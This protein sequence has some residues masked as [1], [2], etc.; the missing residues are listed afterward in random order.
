MG[1]QHHQVCAFV[2]SGAAG[3][4]MDFKMAQSLAIH[5]VTLQEPLNITAVDGS[6]LGSGRVSE[7]TPPF[8]LKVGN[9][10]ELIQFLL[11]HTPKLPIILGF[12]WLTAHNPNID[13]S[14]GVVTEWGTHCQL[15]DFRLLSAVH[16]S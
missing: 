13:W 8:Q 4:F 15:A 10:Q 3:N 16:L 12:P 6:P 1:Q 5:P 9:H 14:R 7:C 11:I 2:D